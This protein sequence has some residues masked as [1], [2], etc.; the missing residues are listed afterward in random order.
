MRTSIATVCLSGTLEDKLRACAAA[1]FEGVEIFEQDLVVSPSTPEQ[2]RDLAQSLGLT[3]DLY[4]PFRDFEG[5]DEDS[6]ADNLRRAEAKFRLMNRLGIDT[7][8][9]CSNVATATVDDDEVAAAQLRRMGET[10]ARYGVRL[11]Y[12]ALAWGRYVSDFEHAWRI[13]ELANHPNVGTCLDSFHI[14]SRRWDPAAIEKIPAEKIFFVQLADAPELSMDVLSWSRHY[15]VFPGEGAFDL[16]TFMGH[17][18]RSG[19]NGPV[20]LEIFNDVFRQAAEERTAVDAMRSLIRLAEQTSIHLQETGAGGTAMEL[21]TLPGVG[22]PLGFNFAEVKAGDPETIRTL[23]YQLGFTSQGTHRS[24]AVELWTQNGARVIINSQNARGLEP[25]ISAIGLDV[26]DALAA[27]S[28]ALQLK[29]TAVPRR[30]QANEEVLQAVAAPDGTEIFLCEAEAGGPGWVR[31]FGSGA[32]VPAEGPI[33]AV[34]HVNLSQPWQ[35]FDEA[36][37]FY[38]STLGLTPR[39]SVEVPSPMGLVRSQVMRSSDGAVRMALNIAPMVFD[40]SGYPQHVA[41]ACSDLVA[42]ARTAVGRGLQFLPV[43]GNYYEDLDARFGLDPEFLAVLKDLNLLY[44]RDADGEFLHFYTS[45][46]GNVFFEVV[47]RRPSYEGYGAPNAP[48]RLAAQ[49]LATA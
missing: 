40:G 16:V 27:A 34:D 19:Y 26:P 10:A 41:F 24:K 25:G 1:G 11:A 38:E 4:Q 33:T 13:V 17:L 48:V 31:E 22:E 12:E 28:R 14:L 8:L 44:D 32:P 49:Y 18:V 9:V 21:S 6:L 35:H 2:I 47:E 3:L 45:T 29:A 46:V 30:S 23:L 39:P 7:M 20:S 37:L 5:V 36:V 15:R 42:L 43:P